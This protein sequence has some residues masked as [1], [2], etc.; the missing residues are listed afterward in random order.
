MFTCRYK[1]MFFPSIFKL[2]GKAS[3]IRTS[4]IFGSPSCLRQPILQS[5][6][7]PINPGHRSTFPSRHIRKKCNRHRISASKKQE[8]N[9]AASKTA[10]SKAT[11]N[12]KE[13]TQQ[14]HSI[15]KCNENNLVG[16]ARN[17]VTDKL[18]LCLYFVIFK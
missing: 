9:N 3:T 18:P 2:D 7:G 15:G 17:D 11:Q 13:D 1:Q 4:L 5:A 10:L 6:A 12:S 8:K 16:Q 14:T